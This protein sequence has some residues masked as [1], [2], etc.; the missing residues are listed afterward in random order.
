L[1]S[2]AIELI[3]RTDCLS[4]I[5]VIIRF[6]I[7]WPEPEKCA[8][9]SMQKQFK[10][11][12]DSEIIQRVLKGETD[13]FETLVIRYEKDILSVVAT[14]VPYDQVEDTAQEVFVRTYKSL[15]SFK[16]KSSF[17]TWVQTITIRTCYD[18][19]R[20]HYRSREIL[21]SSMTE[22]QQEWLDR[23]MSNDESQLKETSTQEEAR[24]VLN[25]AL[26]QLSPKDRVILELVHLEGKT[27]KETASLLGWS[28][29]NVKIR[30]FRARQKLFKV[31]SKM[32]SKETD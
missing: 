11:S 23:I 15:P 28:I 25:L 2:L 21:I 31:L 3:C 6:F 27:G 17:K 26:N 16:F 24:E 7:N 8:H 18:Y 9:L 5:N 12:S 22:P 1:Q 13:A 29:A 30:S 14:H 20:K 19:W 10:G 4:G 32:K